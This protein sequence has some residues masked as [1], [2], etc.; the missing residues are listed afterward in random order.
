MTSQRNYPLCS[1]VIG[2]KVLT[3]KDCAPIMQ[4]FAKN[5]NKIVHSFP[6]AFQR[7]ATLKIPSNV[8]CN[9]PEYLVLV[10]YL[11]SDLSMLG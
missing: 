2:Y 9:N 6:H 3:L 5:L 10:T 1:L 4:L 7:Q 11:I 8:K